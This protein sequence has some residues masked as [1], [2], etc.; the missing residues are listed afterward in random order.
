MVKKKNS[1]SLTD[2]MGW[3][4]VVCEAIIKEC[5]SVCFIAML[6]PLTRI[7]WREE[8]YF[9]RVLSIKIK[10]NNHISGYYTHYLVLLLS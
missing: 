4:G 6:E 3:E 9:Y 8:F 5:E 7:S 1:P 10:A 2:V